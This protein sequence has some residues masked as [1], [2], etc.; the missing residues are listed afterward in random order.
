M[1]LVTHPFTV[2]SHV[3]LVVKSK[4]LDLWNVLDVLHVRG[5]TP[6]SKDTCDLGVGVNVVRG[7]EGSCC[8]VD[9]GGEFDREILLGV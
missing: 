7:D 1:A 2:D 8:V 6:R 4:V 3:N 5:V 9:E